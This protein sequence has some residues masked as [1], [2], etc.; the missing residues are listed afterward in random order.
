AFFAKKSHKEALKSLLI[1]YFQ[2]GGLEV[3][4]NVVDRETLIEAQLHP[5]E[6]RDL[7]VRVSGF[8]A[9]FCN[10]WKTTQDEIINRTEYGNL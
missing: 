9:Y 4:F 6:Y 3:Q 10:L 7:V 5:E 2:R 1:S 8:S